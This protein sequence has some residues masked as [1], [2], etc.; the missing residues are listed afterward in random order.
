MFFVLPFISNI[1]FFIHIHAQWIGILLDTQGYLWSN[2]TQ[3]I[4]VSL[5]S[6][7]DPKDSGYDVPFWKWAKL[8]R[9]ILEQSTNKEVKQDTNFTPKK[10]AI[11]VKR[12]YLIGQN[13][14]EIFCRLKFKRCLISHPNDFIKMIIFGRQT[15]N[16]LSTENFVLWGIEFV[17]CLSLRG[18]C[19]LQMTSDY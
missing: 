7:Y 1:P 8:N 9:K 10:F 19:G 3:I 12:R 15:R 11:K 2:V 13:F 14:A 4:I 6:N 17:L 18:A 5:I 16:I